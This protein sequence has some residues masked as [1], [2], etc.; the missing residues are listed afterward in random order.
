MYKY[1]TLNRN[2]ALDDI[3]AEDVEHG[4]PFSLETVRRVPSTT[5]KSMVWEVSKADGIL[6]K[7]VSY[8][9]ELPTKADNVLDAVNISK[10][11]KGNIDIPYI[12]KITGMDEVN[13]T[14]EI[15]EKGIAYRDPVT[16][17][18][19]DKS[20]YLSGNVKDKLVEARAALEDHPEFQK[21]WMTWKPYSQNVYPMVR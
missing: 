17:N 10:S 4:L 11:Y 14:N 12:S 3:F 20:E 7:R 9:F 8:P 18:I 5:G 21:T 2:K 6:N 15:L 13:V 16:G 19:I 1:G